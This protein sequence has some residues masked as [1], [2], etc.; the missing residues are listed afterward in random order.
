[1]HIN[2]KPKQL[3]ANKVKDLTGISYW[4]EKTVKDY[5][6]NIAAYLQTKLLERSQCIIRFKMPRQK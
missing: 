3:N 1:M 6:S 5:L 2:V 4:Q